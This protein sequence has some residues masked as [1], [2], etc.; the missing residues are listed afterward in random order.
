MLHKRC[1]TRRILH[2]D[3]VDC[4]T[5]AH[6]LGLSSDSDQVRVFIPISDA[7]EDANVVGDAGSHYSK[8]VLEGKID[9][10]SNEIV[11]RGMHINSLKSTNQMSIINMFR[12]KVCSLLS[13]R[14]K[15]TYRRNVEV[16][17][18]P[19]QSDGFSCGPRVIVTAEMFSQLPFGVSPDEV[20]TRL[21]ETI[22]I[23]SVERARHSLEESLRVQGVDK[24]LHNAT[25]REREFV[26]VIVL[27]NQC[28]V[29][30]ANISID[31]LVSLINTDLK[32]AKMVR[33][34]DDERE[35]S[36]DQEAIDS[37]DGKIEV[38]TPTG[39]RIVVEDVDDEEEYAPRSFKRQPY[40]VEVKEKLRLE[41]ENDDGMPS[42]LDA[43]IKQFKRKLR[44]P[45]QHRIDKDIELCFKRA[46]ASDDDNAFVDML[47]MK[48]ALY[49]EDYTDK[50]EYE[51]RS[52]ELHQLSSQVKT[53]IL[54][55]DFVGDVHLG[56]AIDHNDVFLTAQRYATRADKGSGTTASIGDCWNDKN[57]CN[58]AQQHLTP[59]WL[60]AE[61]AKRQGTHVSGVS[62]YEP[63]KSGGIDLV[64]VTLTKAKNGKLEEELDDIAV[65]HLG[66]DSVDQYKT[67]SL[68]WASIHIF[69]HKKHHKKPMRVNVGSSYT[70]KHWLGRRFTTIK[71]EY[72]E[73]YDTCHGQVWLTGCQICWSKK[74]RDCL[75][76]VVV[77]FWTPTLG[78]PDDYDTDIVNEFGRNGR[79]DA[80]IEQMRKLR[81][82]F[83]HSAVNNKYKKNKDACLEW[84]KTTEDKITYK[85]KESYFGHC[86]KKAGVE[87][88][89]QKNKT[90]CLEH[91]KTTED[92]ITYKQKESYQ[93]YCAA[94][95]HGGNKKKDGSKID[96]TAASARAKNGIMKNA[97]NKAKSRETKRM[98]TLKKYADD[99]K[100]ANFIMTRNRC[101]GCGQVN[102]PTIVGLRSFCSTDD[103]KHCTIPKNKKD[104]TK[105]YQGA[106]I[107]N[108][109]FNKVTQYDGVDR[110]KHVSTLSNDEKNK[111]I[112]KARAHEDVLRDRKRQ[113]HDK[114]WKKLKKA[115]T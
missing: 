39:D 15:V 79:S 75:A 44:L 109:K 55:P 51:T 8:Y 26:N 1:D 84:C 38:E 36:A 13:D 24:V 4:D 60:A 57:G 52:N 21:K 64:G 42:D 91:C 78:L 102:P 54:G 30:I 45:T 105:G 86:G 81:V 73:W 67:T 68:V 11:L 88:H 47:V 113:S 108:P 114:H 6:T 14:F 101:L 87:S 48:H 89:Y 53:A 74:K 106:T 112:A 90:A 82:T 16:E 99:P 66:Y 77:D 12:D 104:L 23:V 115:K 34:E 22:T 25:L 49:E 37:F 19:Q 69:N 61:Y 63:C 27:T 58:I 62:D 10:D 65:K 28:I 46:T 94:K 20:A 85:Q 31:I 83:R 3:D 5:L 2:S 18:V 40:S 33:D 93:G 100:K 96:R 41:R 7:M 72:V 97:D 95:T 107:P 103:C 35:E 56:T 80:V 98:T 29:Y 59:K 92:K 76:E 43:R 70:A 110:W 71:N 50:T 17:R 9:R 111:E 32:F